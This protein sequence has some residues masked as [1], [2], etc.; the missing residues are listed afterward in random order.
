MQRKRLYN[1]K[2][3]A[4]WLA[5]YG[6][7]VNPKTFRNRMETGCWSP[8]RAASVPANVVNY[9]YLIDGVPV[10]E[11]LEANNPDVSYNTFIM[12]IRKGFTVGDA[13]RRPIIVRGR[14]RKSRLTDNDRDTLSLIGTLRK[15][16]RMVWHHKRQ[17]EVMRCVLAPYV[18]DLAEKGIIN[19]YQRVLS[20][21]AVG[22]QE[23]EYIAEGR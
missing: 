23:I 4:E 7:T 11:W 8:E 12:R 20:T 16:E 5:L 3:A 21:N 19:C 13:A 2:T 9:K 1:G 14:Q 15:G 22:E 17:D 6:H 18:A 10:K